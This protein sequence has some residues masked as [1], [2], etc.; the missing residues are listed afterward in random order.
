MEHVTVAANDCDP[1]P[2]S[3]PLVPQLPDCPPGAT[4][5]TE[6]RGFKPA[7]TSLR[8]FSPASVS[9]W[10]LVRDSLS[11]ATRVFEDVWCC[12]NWCCILMSAAR[13]R[14]AE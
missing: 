5:L 6:E 7:Y 9:G 11:T 13:R 3:P 1:T 14:C 4:T 2:P 10:G 8:L 12:S